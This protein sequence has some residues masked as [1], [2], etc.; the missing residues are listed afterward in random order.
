MWGALPSALP[1]LIYPPHPYLPAS[2]LDSNTSQVQSQMGVL[3]WRWQEHPPGPRTRITQVLLPL[4]NPSAARNGASLCRLLSHVAG[5]RHQGHILPFV[6]PTFLIL[7]KIALEECRG[8]RTPGLGKP[9]R[10][11]PKDVVS[12]ISSSTS[13]S[14][15]KCT[16]AC[17]PVITQSS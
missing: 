17:F 14:P 15:F 11:T 5:M 2:P 1:G 9:P 10:F 16:F 12:A 13:F 6:N 7:W 3:T 4:H 8:R